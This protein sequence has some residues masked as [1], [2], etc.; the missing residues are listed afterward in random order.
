ML[1]GFMLFLVV[2][3]GAATVWGLGA[4]LPPGRLLCQAQ[5]ADSLGMWAAGHE[6]DLVPCGS[7]SEQSPDPG[8]GPRCCP[9]TPW[10]QEARDGQGRDLWK[11]N[12]SG[13]RTQL[14]N[15]ERT[16]EPQVARVTD[17]RSAGSG[18][19]A[20]WLW[21]CAHS[22]CAVVRPGKGCTLHTMSAIRKRYFSP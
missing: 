8:L 7:S 3:G 20:W 19:Q 14:V 16:P 9:Q 6:E 10:S 5:W 13:I 2:T 17:S 12:R 18:E 1:Q 4:G 11:E 22:R 21:V 15:C